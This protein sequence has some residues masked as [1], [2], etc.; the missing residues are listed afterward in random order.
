MAARVDRPWR[1]SLRTR[2]VA[3]FFLLSAITVLVVGAIAYFRATDD[4]TRAVYDRLDSVA[5]NKRDS[6]ERWI[7]EQTRNVVYVGSIPGLGDAA[8]VLLDPASPAADRAAADT[9]I[10][11][12]L[13]TILIGTADAEELYILDLDGTVQLS[14]LALHEGAN[15]AK[16]PFFSEGSSHTTVQNVYTSTLTNRPT[17]TVATPLFD[18]DGGGQRVGVL[19]ANV[20]LQR[21]DRIILERTGL[22]ES[23]RTY[24][25]GADHRLVQGATG[26]NPTPVDSAG[27]SAVLAG[28]DGQGLYSDDRGVPVVGVYRWLT[29]R[30]AGLL[31]EI[32]Q[33]EAL[34]SARQLALT[35][36]LVGLASTLVLALGI[37]IV[38][39][40]LTRPILSL[41]ATASR[42]AGGDLDAV[43]GIRSADEVG[44][45]ATAFDAM[46]GQLR[47]NVETLERRVE[48]RTAELSK[49]RQYYA[50]LVDVSPVAVVT[51]DLDELVSAWN[52]AATTLF[53]YEPQEAIGRR[54]DELILRSDALQEEGHELARE[55]LGGRV[56]RL[57]QRMRKDGSLVDLEILM[58][59]LVVDGE[60]IGFYAIYHD[61]SELQAA[62][63]EADEANQAKSSFLAAMS[64]EI[65]TPMNAVIGMSGL[66][67]DTP[68]DDEQRDYAE[69][70]RT[71]GEALLTIIN[72]ILDFS[73]IEAGRIE[74]DAAPF[75]LVTTIEGALDVMG[76]VAARKGVELV[77]A[78]DSDLPPALLGD[79]GRVRQIVLNLLSNAIKF[80]EQG[81]VVLR[82]RAGRDGD[83]WD[84]RLDIHDTGIGIPPDRIGRLFQSFSQADASISRRFGGTGLGLAISR[85]LAE[86]MGGSLEAE[87]AGVPG[88]GS[89]F[90]LR[91]RLAEA[92]VHDQR[93]GDEPASPD[94][95]AGLAAVAGRTILV[96]DDN[97]TNLRILVAQL[98]RLGLAVIATSSGLAARD[99]VL[100]A[101]DAFAAVV[102]DHRM[103]DLDGLGVAAAIAA[104]GLASPPPVIVL[105]SA[106]Q[107]DRD[108]GG[109][110]AFVSKP[111]KPA[112]LRELLA[113][114]LSGGLTRDAAAGARDAARPVAG[115]AVAEAAPLRILLA[116]DNAVNQKL[117]LRLLERMGYTADVASNGL[118]ALSAIEAQPY[119]VVLM[120]VQMP[121]LDGL[122]ASRE[123]RRRWPDRALRIVAMTANAM[124]G[125]RDE[126]LA[127]GMDDYVSK[128]IRPDELRAALAGTR[129]PSAG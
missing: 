91:V 128:P 65:R 51:M 57:G 14:T 10:R 48:E 6:L 117:A 75:S 47:E 85:R 92:P 115:R 118:E 30:G 69:T 119:D 109:V 80:T 5:A 96:A 42:V 49:Q 66:L 53:G 82:V 37:W 29:D 35:I 8:R 32:S 127:A 122:E 39:R 107:R 22:G 84:L 83:A 59:P 28:Q 70:I 98:E 100:A 34:G 99:Q 88:E 74:L 4:L 126:C 77:Y 123:I 24:L 56:Q 78:I 55:A 108:A 125:D 40:R 111:V 12:D 43:S 50:S 124:E 11:D 45:L 113:R 103:P 93:D 114:V 95:A 86:L 89:T 58:V 64:H 44:T 102:I 79:S 38:A 121:E 61:I 71:S 106:G 25:V 72:D 87:S 73:K 7:D 63:R 31:A 60:P 33:D 67:V 16:E 1:R 9:R 120:D 112:Q 15:Q 104:A 27:I 62:R 36:G 20:N 105:S 21:L 101:P 41:A 76:P 90:H 17:I 26:V 19:A 46:T 2:L 3:Y 68:L 54:I 52:P 18:Q 110:A 116:E 13:H 94:G 81:E 23:G 129:V 97:E